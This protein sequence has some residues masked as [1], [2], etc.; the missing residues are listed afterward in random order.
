MSGAEPP[1]YGHD[2][3]AL[4]EASRIAGEAWVV[5]NANWAT[6][7]LERKILRAE[8]EKTIRETDPGAKAADIATRVELNEAWQ[9]A[10][11]AEV[12]AQRIAQ[13]AQVR[14]KA[15]QLQVE[16]ARTEHVTIRQELR[17]LPGVGP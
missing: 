11:Y 12:D 16:I 2:L 1:R 7:K 10:S 9:N 6:M 14:M 4:V 15:A 8:I 17:N 5:A 13:T 3:M